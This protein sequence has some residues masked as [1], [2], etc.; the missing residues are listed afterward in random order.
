MA[1]AYVAS[2]KQL[3]ADNLAS[4]KDEARQ[5]NGDFQ[6]LARF[7][8]LPASFGPKVELETLIKEQKWDKR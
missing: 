1:G 5:V 4:K 3:S 2:L 8:V 6:F 7:N